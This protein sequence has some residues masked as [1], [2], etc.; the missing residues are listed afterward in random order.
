MGRDGLYEHDWVHLVQDV[1]SIYRGHDTHVSLGDAKRVA[2]S[3]R[4]RY[5]NGRGWNERIR[6]SEAREHIL[7]LIEDE[8]RLLHGCQT[9][10]PVVESGTLA[11]EPIDVPFQG[12]FSLEPQ[13]DLP[14]VIGGSVGCDPSGVYLWA[15]EHG[16][17]YLINYVGETRA[18]F[19]ARTKDQVTWI[20]DNRDRI[21]DVDRF[22]KGEICVL[23]EKDN[24]PSYD[25]FRREY[26]PAIEDRLLPAYRVFWA[27]LSASDT[28][29]VEAA[30]LHQLRGSPYGGFLANRAKPNVSGVCLRISSRVNLLG[31]P[32]EIRIP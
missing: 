1:F 28:K 29:R 31:L 17:G 3:I 25:R 23:H 4:D 19:A 32:Q 6:S 12:P 18:G 11:A 16:D 30:I 8:L 5:P 14:H 21:V 10:S 13:A 9:R 20:R 27:P 24:L 2:A 22:L 15:I 7:R 26:L